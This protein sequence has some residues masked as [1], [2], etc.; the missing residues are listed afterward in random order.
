MRDPCTEKINHPI[1]SYLGRPNLPA[2]VDLECSLECSNPLSSWKSPQTYPIKLYCYGILF[3]YAIT[4]DMT[5]C[6]FIYQYQYYV[7]I[8]NF[9]EHPNNPRFLQLHSMGDR[10]VRLWDSTSPSYSL[11]ARNSKY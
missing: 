10:S 5:K 11:F 2:E 8:R 6:M 9:C 7:T 3:Y 4:H 1:I